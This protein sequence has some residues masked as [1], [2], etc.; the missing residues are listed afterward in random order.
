MRDF[1]SIK[2]NN[3]I[4][5]VIILF[6]LLSILVLLTNNSANKVV[7]SNESNSKENMANTNAF[8]IM[9]ETEA[10]S[11]SYEPS[12]S[13]NAFAI[14]LETEAGSGSYEPSSSSLWPGDGYIFN[15]TLSRCENG[16]I[17]TWNDETKRIVLTTSTSDKCYVY[18]EKKPDIVYLADY[19]IKNVYTG[20]DGENGLY[21]HDG[22]GTYINANQEAGDNSYRY[23]GGDY[24]L[25]N[26]AISEGYSSIFQDTTDTNG[27]IKFYCNGTNQY[28]GYTCYSS[29]N[30]FMVANNNDQYTLHEAINFALLQ[31]YLISN[32][33]DNY[34]CFGSNDT[35]CPYDNLYRI[36]G[37][38]KNNNS[39][40]VKIIKNDYEKSTLLGTDGG[41]DSP[42]YSSGRGHT[43]YY[44]GQLSTSEIPLY[45]W[46]R[47]GNDNWSESNLNILNLKQ[48]FANS[49][50]K[51]WNE[52]IASN[53][54]YI[55]GYYPNNVP[56]KTFYN[57][58]S[59]GI[60]W[61]GKIGLIYVSDYGYAASPDYWNTNLSTYRISSNWLH[62]GLDEWTITPYL[63]PYNISVCIIGY[64]GD[65][66]TSG[67]YAGSYYPR[68]VRPTF[69]LNS[70][71]AYI[72]GTGT[73]S[74]PFRIE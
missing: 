57:A 28:F 63:D 53:T 8:A 20:I 33:I 61:S 55:D 23:T 66:S 73:Q 69:Y 31:E 41:Y 26:K 24:I 2:K 51:E 13:S 35:S 70:D 25:T 36:I 71:V 6:L 72:S 7:I 74:D 3:I 17:L 64:D 1:K 46:D 38:F 30:Y 49:I 54:W 67:L 48:N 37:V 65:I 4:L 39:Y 59:S 60:S 45:Y 62:M 15:E 56:V 21:Y 44:K 19:I 32:N 14:M 52:L 68:A 43:Y 12:S 5:I 18:F 10:G 9:L 27:L 11:G 16:G 34:I 29:N 58:E 22:V 50:E 47:S 42:S 40:Q